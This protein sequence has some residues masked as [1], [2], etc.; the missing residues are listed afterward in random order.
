M[1]V[2]KLMAF[3]NGE[4]TDE[5]TVDLFQTLVD[6]GLAWSLQG[7]YGRAAND[8]IEAGLVHR[9]RGEDFV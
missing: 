9:N 6:T 7:Y 3:E 4:L 1:D 5:E 2:T 8:L